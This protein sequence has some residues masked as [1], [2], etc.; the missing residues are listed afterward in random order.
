MQD[1]RLPDR[2][3]PGLRARRIGHRG[4]VATGKDRRIGLGLKGVGD[5][6]EPLV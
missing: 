3:D 2:I 1:W 4:N 5:G 6:N